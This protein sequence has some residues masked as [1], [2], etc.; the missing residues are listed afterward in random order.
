MR[1]CDGIAVFPYVLGLDDGSLDWTPGGSE[2]QWQLQVDGGQ[3]LSVSAH[4]YVLSGLTASTTYSVKVRAVCTDELT[5]DWSVA[6]SVITSAGQEPGPQPGDSTGIASVCDIDVSLSPN[7][8]STVVM[9]SADG[10]H[11]VE[12]ADITGRVVIRQDG[13]DGTVTLNVERLARSVYFVRLRGEGYT[14]I[15]KLV[16]S[17]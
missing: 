15:R 12:V 2:S 6:I 8:A 11:S 9:V 17:E 10:L 7:P 4:P 14:A 3:P 5:S 1:N 13:L 16:V